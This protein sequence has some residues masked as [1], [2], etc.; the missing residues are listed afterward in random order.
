[1][2][3]LTKEFSI[4][5]ELQVE[6]VSDTEARVTLEPL[7]R[8]FGHTLGNALR[9]I[10]LSS[11]PG[12]AVT[13]VHIEGI[14][15]EYA[16]R[17]G[18]R[19]DVVDILLNLKQLALR[20]E[21]GESAELQLQAKGPGEVKA[22]DV[23]KPANVEVANPDYVIAHL[24]EGASLNMNML[25]ERGRGYVPAEQKL[26]DLDF[27]TE[28]IGKLRLDASFSPIKRVSYTVDSTR[29]GQRTDLDK[30]VLEL[31]TNG[32][33]TAD[34]AV[35][36]AATILQEHLAPITE[37]EA[38][39]RPGAASQVVMTDPFFN[40][41]LEEL[42][43]LGKSTRNKLEKEGVFYIGELV[44]MT[45]LDLLKMPNI[46][47]KSLDEIVMA[48]AEEDMQLGLDIDPWEAP[49]A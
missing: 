21:E 9:R 19:E 49:A 40:Q 42:K 28:T 45:E 44:R 36:R 34:E 8:G 14:M 12:S 31:E 15:H 39:Q 17:E 5:E 27:E 33:I 48:L 13:E 46:G 24:A 6:Q 25:V 4:P 26:D 23:R 2:Q 47:K 29:K 41:R 38:R 30:L 16:T 22:G 18:V 11:M 37:P 20:L 3:D 7:E 35:R 43:N 10:L 32:T 1:M